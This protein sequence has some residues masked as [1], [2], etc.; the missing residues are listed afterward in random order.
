MK[1][2]LKSIFIV[3]LFSII[4]LYSC[5]NN[6]VISPITDQPV[7]PQI[8][9]FPVWSPD[10]A[11]IIYN[12]YGITQINSGGS[13]QVNRDSAGLWMINA[14]GTNP[15]M[16]RKGNDVNSDWS[17][18]GKW[19]VYEVGSQI[20]K[21]AIVKDIIDTL[22][23]VQLTFEG[24]NFFPAWSPDGKWIAYDSNNDTKDGGY[25]IWKMNPDGEDKS[26]IVEGRMAS[27]SPDSKWIIYIGFHSEIFKINVNNLSDRVQ[28]THLNEKN[29]YATD[30]IFPKY[31]PDGTKIAFSSNNR[32]WIMDNNGNNIKQLINNGAQ[33]SWS[34]DGQN[35]VYVGWTDKKYNPENNGTLWIM[36]INGT[37]KRQLTYG[38]K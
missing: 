33:S 24:R 38:V 31:S 19:I 15:H 30:N 27:W 28:L 1:L 2:Q 7:Y 23:I 18:D 37:Y 22:K 9:A 12:H 20:Y 26:I 16:I 17:P 11:K 14:D 8:D 32:I 35:I 5:K 13:Y 25:R 10:G 29:I 3:M 34:P 4:L 21:A 6:P 36:N